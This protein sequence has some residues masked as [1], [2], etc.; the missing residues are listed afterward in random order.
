MTK[1]TSYRGI[2]VDMESLRNENAHVPAAGNMSVNARGDLLGK[3]GVV[4]KTVDQI[5]RENQRVRTAIQQTG[6]KDDVEPA[7]DEVASVTKSTKAATSTTSRKVEK[8]LSNRD[9][10][11]DDGDV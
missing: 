1:H 9:I 6:L 10:V 8:E 3:G 7:I 5:A 2:Q 11:Q 4:S